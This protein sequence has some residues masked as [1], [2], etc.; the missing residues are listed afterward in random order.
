MD[1]RNFSDIF[2]SNAWAS[3]PSKNIW[4]IL[5]ILFI[6]GVLIGLGLIINDQFNSKN[7]SKSPSTPEAESSCSWDEIETVY[8]FYADWCSHCKEFDKVWAKFTSMVRDKDVKTV[9]INGDKHNDKLKKYKVNAYPTVIY[10]KK[11]GNYLHYYGKRDAEA[12]MR[13]CE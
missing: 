5:V 7:I 12:M 6:V 10:V 2:N 11:N 1:L 4:S 8:W 13:Y 9:K 3:D